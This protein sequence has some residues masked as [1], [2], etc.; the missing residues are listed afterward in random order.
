MFAVE[1]DGLHDQQRALVAVVTD[2]KRR[3]AVSG[4]LE[5]S[6]R[7]ME[8]F[9][10]SDRQ[11]S[12]SS[13]ILKDAEGNAVIVGTVARSQNKQRLNGCQPGNSQESFYTIAPLL[14][15]GCVNPGSFWPFARISGT[16]I[17]EGLGEGLGSM[18]S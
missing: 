3:R 11:N 2:S 18:G 16:E 17:S 9:L 5:T 13:A 8:R 6:D 10:C 12:L 1:F 14:D 7:L 15:G 4:V